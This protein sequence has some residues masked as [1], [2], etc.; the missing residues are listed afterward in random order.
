MDRIS[1]YI[2]EDEI[3]EKILAEIKSLRKIMRLGSTALEKKMNLIHCN[4]RTGRSLNPAVGR[5]NCYED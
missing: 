1:Q 5:M 4:P 2:F 3:S